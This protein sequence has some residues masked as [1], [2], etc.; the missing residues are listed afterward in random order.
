LVNQII[1]PKSGTPAIAK[2]KGQGGKRAKELPLYHFTIL[3]L[4]MAEFI[5]KKIV[6]DV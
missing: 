5:G 4:L 3:P 1:A 2:A 6:D